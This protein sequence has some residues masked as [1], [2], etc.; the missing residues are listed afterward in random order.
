LKELIDEQQAH[1]LMLGVLALAPVIG[2]MWGL[3][4]KRIGWGLALG[5][6]V[7]VGNY[8]LWTV[9]NV[10]T[11]RLGLDTVKNLLVNLGLFVVV[12]IVVG[13]GAGIFAAKQRLGQTVPEGEPVENGRQFGVDHE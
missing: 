8:A 7:G 12:G 3:V 9:Y 2:L 13:L 1:R 5:L 6:L 4:A 10:I 11:E